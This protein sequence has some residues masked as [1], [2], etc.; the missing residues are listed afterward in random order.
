MNRR[1]FLAALIAGAT[2]D[3]ERLLWIPGRKTISIPAPIT[4]R[5]IGPGGYEQLQYFYNRYLLLGIAERPELRGLF[6]QIRTLDARDKEPTLVSEMPTAGWPPS[7]NGDCSGAAEP[8]PAALVIPDA[9]YS[10]RNS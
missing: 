6:E 5:I 8:Q 4:N 3:P 9:A 1:D 2:Q 10:P 7:T